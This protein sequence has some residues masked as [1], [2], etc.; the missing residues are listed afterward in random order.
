MLPN[1]AELLGGYD[2]RLWVSLLE[3]VT[4]FHDG[5]M[6]FQFKNGAEIEV[7]TS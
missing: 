2:E 6:V 3:K 7:V 1:Y 5:R 4:V